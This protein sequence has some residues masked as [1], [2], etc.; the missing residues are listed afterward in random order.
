MNQMLNQKGK[1]MYNGYGLL[2]PNI[3]HLRPVNRIKDK[4]SN[5]IDILNV[6]SSKSINQRYK[7]EELAQSELKIK[8]DN[9]TFKNYM[10]NLCKSYIDTPE[11][12]D[13]VDSLRKLYSILTNSLKFG[14]LANSSSLYGGDEYERNF[15][16]SFVRTTDKAL[17]IIIEIQLKWKLDKDN[18]VILEYTNIT[19]E[20]TT[21]TVEYKIG[22]ED[23]DNVIPE[24][25]EYLNSLLG[26][27]HSV[28]LTWQR[29]KYIV[30][31]FNYQVLSLLEYYIN[32]DYDYF[33]Q[34]KYILVLSTIYY[35]IDSYKNITT[36]V[37]EPFNTVVNVYPLTYNYGRYSG[38]CSLNSYLASI[39]NDIR[40][41]LSEYII[42]DNSLGDQGLIGLATRINMELHN[43]LS[44]VTIPT[45]TDF[46][47]KFKLEQILLLNKLIYNI[48][49]TTDYKFKELRR[50]YL[51]ILIVKVKLNHLMN[52][53]IKYDKLNLN[54]LTEAFRHVNYSRN[55]I[56]RIVVEKYDYNNKHYLILPVSLY[57]ISHAVVLVIE[58]NDINGSNSN[59]K[60]YV[61]DLNIFNINFT[62]QS[63]EFDKPNFN[64]YI[65]NNQSQRLRDDN[66]N[67]TKFGI[68][69]DY[70][71]L[72]N[73]NN[74]DSNISLNK[75]YKKY[76]SQLQYL[77]HKN[78]YHVYYVNISKLFSCPID[79]T[80]NI[81]QRI[82]NDLFS[83]IPIEELGVID[84]NNVNTINMFSICVNKIIEYFNN[85]NVDVPW[86]YIIRNIDNLNYANLFFCIYYIF[87]IKVIKD[88]TISVCLNH[89]SLRVQLYKYLLDKLADKPGPK[90]LA[91]NLSGTIYH[92]I[93]EVQ[94]QITAN[95]ANA[96]Y[97]FDS[98]FDKVTDWCDKLRQ[99]IDRD[100]IIAQIKDEIR[101]IKQLDKPNTDFISKV[102]FNM[103]LPFN[104]S[105]KNCHNVLDYVYKLNCSLGLTTSEPL[106]TS[107][108]QL[109]S[110]TLVNRYSGGSD[111]TR[112]SSIDSI[113]FVHVLQQ[114]LMFL[115]VLI[116]VVI[117][118]VL[119]VKGV[120]LITSNNN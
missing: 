108:D 4:L 2:E 70:V 103:T 13:N 101:M 54:I 36:E 86:E 44:I 57:Q 61:I 41:G 71:R 7:L 115:L 35:Y 24:I 14:L 1:S 59:D 98:M 49:V 17:Q 19:D 30:L 109:K 68:K 89:Y 53:I 114:I 66:E 48:N 18:C 83:M 100:P 3:F 113:K 58:R 80:F 65:L 51:S 81:T 85:N 26:V 62:C 10:I 112:T 118:V 32:K 82:Y 37:Y 50:L 39:N 6:N 99:S 33:K 52:M 74:E 8:E 102:R 95:K 16:Y 5:P 34:T 107:V 105:S 20:K 46:I 104:L 67:I 93:D 87:F 12:K 64:V 43:M 90:N 25:M 117:V 78:I 40:K 60:A 42:N 110:Y 96:G 29:D 116:I 28:D 15:A 91:D 92:R 31:H 21:K 111:S 69:V 120:E 97:L 84:R 73:V 56:H 106:K 23:T 63:N 55:D 119:L 77:N 45:F 88:N 94:K 38:D 27:F 11:F 22:T 79:D 9:Q 76:I 47:N 72:T 75:Y